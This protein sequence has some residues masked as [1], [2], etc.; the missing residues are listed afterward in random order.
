[1]V[2]QRMPSEERES[3]TE[4]VAETSPS[5]CISEYLATSSMTGREDIE[6]LYWSRKLQAK[7]RL[8]NEP[9]CSRFCAL[10]QWTRSPGGSY[11]LHQFGVGLSGKTGE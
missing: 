1:M 7:P 4:N 5:P 2:R 3:G 9:N 11:R 6:R 8:R 10:L